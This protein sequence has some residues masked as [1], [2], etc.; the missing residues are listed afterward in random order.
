MRI[1]FS[2]KSE[3]RQLTVDE[4]VSDGSAIT[5]TIVVDI[6]TLAVEVFSDSDQIANGGGCANIREILSSLSRQANFPESLPPRI[7]SIDLGV[8]VL[9]VGRVGETGLDV[10]PGIDQ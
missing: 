2:W 3:S 10:N 5:Q 9:K 6:T 8:E 4:V 1:Y 7:H